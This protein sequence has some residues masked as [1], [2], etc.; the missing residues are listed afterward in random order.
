VASGTIEAEDIAIATEMGGQVVELFA[1]EG[2]RV[3][4]G[5][6]LLQLDQAALLAQWE[7]TEAGVAQAQAA[8]EAA[9]AQ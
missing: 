1:G 8:V 3:D 5:D 9:E 4:A 6:V 7:G 2:D